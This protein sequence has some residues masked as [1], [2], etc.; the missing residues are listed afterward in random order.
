MGIVHPVIALLSSN[1]NLLQN[2][3][4]EAAPQGPP[5]ASSHPVPAVDPSYGSYPPPYGTA[6]PYGSSS[7]AAAAPQCY[8]APSI[9][10]YL[11][12]LSV[13]FPNQSS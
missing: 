7:W 10:K 13:T 6:A 12:Y 3:M 4:A 8:N 1:C 11:L 9:I 2:F 5:P